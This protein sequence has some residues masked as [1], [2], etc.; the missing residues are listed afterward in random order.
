MTDFEAVEPEKRKYGSSYTWA[1]V[2]T[3]VLTR[4]SVATFEEI[5]TDKTAGTRRGFNWI[6]V[7]AALS[8]LLSMLITSVQLGAAYMAVSLTFVCVTLLSGPLSVLFYAI[9]IGFT[10]FTA[11]LLGGRKGAYGELVYAMASFIA[12]LSF[13]NIALFLIL[14]ASTLSL[15]LMNLIVSIFTFVLQVMAIR[16]V[17]QFGVGRAVVA[18]VLPMIVLV[19][20]FVVCFLTLLPSVITTEYPEILL[21]L[22]AEAR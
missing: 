17:H 12:P 2:W 4:P 15:N 3:A 11:R 9:W 21:T 8:A 22:T 19:V 1:E 16:V 6:F 10:Q 20:L 7:S 13:L 5:L 14:S 18:L